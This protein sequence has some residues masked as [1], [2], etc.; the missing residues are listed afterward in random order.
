MWIS[1]PIFPLRPKT[2]FQLWLEENRKSVLADDPD[3]EEMDIIKEAMSRFRALAGE[4]R[5]VRLKNRIVLKRIAF[6][7]PNA[8]SALFRIP[9]FADAY[10]RLMRDSGERP[11]V[12][13]P[14]R[15]LRPCMRNDMYLGPR[16]VRV[17]G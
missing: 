4:E 3:L 13:L 5:L 14:P 8:P 2:G 15:V 1:Y 9:E 11:S 10:D 16:Y 6:K 12:P 17:R 7:H